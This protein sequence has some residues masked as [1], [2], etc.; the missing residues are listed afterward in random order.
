M[1][2][3]VLWGAILILIIIAGALWFVVGPGKGAVSGTNGETFGTYAYTCN[4]GAQFTL[5]PSADLSTVIAEAGSQGPFTGKVT[6]V[7]TGSSQYAGG[8][9]KFTGAGEEVTFT[10]GSETM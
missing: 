2:Q 1:K 8:N 4:N 3:S 5:T 9:L 6:L 7:Q 10:S